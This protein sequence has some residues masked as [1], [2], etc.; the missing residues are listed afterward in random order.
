MLITRALSCVKEDKEEFWISGQSIN[1]KK[2]IKGFVIKITKLSFPF[3]SSH[4]CVLCK[5]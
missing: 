4:Q 5:H 3:K 2:S 1:H